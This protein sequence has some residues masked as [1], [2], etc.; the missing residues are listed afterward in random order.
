MVYE[1][2]K[3]FIGRTIQ[4]ISEIEKDLEEIGRYVCADHVLI[5]VLSI[6]SEDMR[7]ISEPLLYKIPETHKLSYDNM[8]K[9]LRKVFGV[10]FSDF[11]LPF[12][13]MRN[14]EL[15]LKKLKEDLK[16][17]EE[18]RT[19]EKRKLEELMEYGEK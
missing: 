9:Y 5:E 1:L 4:T 2:R 17:L 13:I 10:D 11:T 6:K 12:F 3:R 7:E 15:A 18:L 19:E 8:E 16:S 14:Q